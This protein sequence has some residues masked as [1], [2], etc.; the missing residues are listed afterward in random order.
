ME[1]KEIGIHQKKTIVSIHTIFLDEIAF[2]YM[3]PQ[4][5]KTIIT[6]ATVE[7]GDFNILSNKW[8]FLDTWRTRMQY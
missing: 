1:L 8:L 7:V 5:T 2:R 6:R 4:T 3:P